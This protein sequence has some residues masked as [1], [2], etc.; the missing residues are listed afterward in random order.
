MGR[1]SVWSW[2]AT[3]VQRETLT[4]LVRQPPLPLSLSLALRHTVLNMSCISA[5]SYHPLTLTLALCPVLNRSPHYGH[6]QRHRGSQDETGAP[7][8][9]EAERGQLLHQCSQ[10]VFSQ[11]PHRGIH[12]TVY[13]EWSLTVGCACT[14]S[15]THTLRVTQRFL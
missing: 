9:P 3:S 8:A 4:R 13:Y 1:F 11:A 12:I 2:W 10:L 7:G 6:Q 14:I 15:H 5:W